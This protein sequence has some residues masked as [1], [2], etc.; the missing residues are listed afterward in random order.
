MTVHHLDTAPRLPLEM[1]RGGLGSLRKKAPYG[2]VRL[3]DERLVLRAATVD[4]AKL[5]AY[6]RVCGFPEGSAELPPTYPHILG[7]PLQMRLMARPGFPFPLL[8]LVHT[9]IELRR[10]RT[11]RADERP[12]ISVHA[13]ELRPHRRGTAFTVVTEAHIGGES[14]WDSRSTYLCRHPG[15]DTAGTEARDT[16]TGPLPVRTTWDL[17]AGL[18]RRYA[19][20]SGDRN[21]IHLRP[22][23]ARMFGFP[24]PIAH[25]MWTFAHCL[26]EAGPSGA[27]AL[28]AHARFTA[29]VL[30][31]SAVTFRSASAGDGTCVEVRGGKDGERLHLTGSLYRGASAG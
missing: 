5:R 6:A 1:A 23:T 18:G 21:P 24:R 8:G 22:L 4:A 25:G 31:P 29:P 19:A 27:G 14:V 26:A 30:L 13:E 17:P 9:D 3:P 16:A 11:V 20:A 10:R 2:D 12:D 28:T 7:F 15:N